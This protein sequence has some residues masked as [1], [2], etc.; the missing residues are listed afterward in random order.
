MARRG[1]SRGVTSAT[2]IFSFETPSRQRNTSHGQR[3][4]RELLRE[5]TGSNSDSTSAR[6]GSTS[7]SLPQSQGGS[8]QGGHP[9]ETDTTTACTPRNTLTSTEVESKA[10]R[11]SSIGSIGAR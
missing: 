5:I 2:P 9:E 3:G 10:G 4:A 1:S 8:S 6:P 11:D 7:T